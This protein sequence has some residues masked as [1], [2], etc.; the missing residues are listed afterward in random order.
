MTHDNKIIGK[1]NKNDPIYKLLLAKR[2]IQKTQVFN[3]NGNSKG[4]ASWGQSMLDLKENNLGAC[5]KC[6]GILQ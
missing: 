3:L 4:H 1:I 2:L 6:K 5:S